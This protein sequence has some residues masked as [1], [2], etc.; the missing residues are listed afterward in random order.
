V[1]ADTLSRV[2]SITAPPSYDAMTASQDS[3]DELRALL[4]SNTALRLEKH[5]I[6][7]TALSISCDSSTGKPQP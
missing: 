1:V 2:E 4:A 6:P 7:G 3:D 5:L